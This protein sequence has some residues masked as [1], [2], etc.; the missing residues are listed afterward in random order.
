MSSLFSFFNERKC[1]VR[2]K[3][4]K[5]DVRRQIGQIESDIR[6]VQPSFRNYETSDPYGCMKHNEPETDGGKNDSCHN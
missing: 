2:D 5:Q 4:P 3:P 6:R 1:D